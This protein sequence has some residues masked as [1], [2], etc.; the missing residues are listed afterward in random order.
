[1]AGLDLFSRAGL[2]EEVVRK[3]DRL[4]E[5]LAAQ[6]QQERLVLGGRPLSTRYADTVIVPVAAAPAGPILARDESPRARY[7]LIQ[8]TGADAVRV[9]FA[10]RATGKTGLILNAGDAYEMAPVWSNLV[11]GK[12]WVWAPSGATEV[13]VT[14]IGGGE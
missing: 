3:L 8:V 1:M 6:A 11:I 14:E 9:E 13:T 4:T 2:L 12:I 7:R 5:L 10:E